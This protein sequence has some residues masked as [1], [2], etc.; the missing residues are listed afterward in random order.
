[1]IT[2]E[3]IP[4]SGAAQQLLNMIEGEGKRYGKGKA[5]K[6]IDAEIKI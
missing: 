1:M 6:K 3:R 4:M 5:E 2:D